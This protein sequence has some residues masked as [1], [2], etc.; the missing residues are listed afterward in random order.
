[1]GLGA[2]EGNASFVEGCSFNDGYNGGIGVFGT[3]NLTLKNNV[4]YRAVG[5]AIDLEGKDH[6]VIGNLLT[7]SLSILTFRVGKIYASADLNW[8]G[9]LNLEKAKDFTVTGN[10]IAGAEK[11]G[12]RFPGV[13]CDDNTKRVYGNEVCNYFV[14]VSRDLLKK[15]DIFQLIISF[16]R[17]FPNKDRK[18]LKRKRFLI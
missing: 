9:A 13:P 8:D 6:K 15:L 4:I 1:M 7:T 10:S 5:P 16:S 3:N 12:I 17:Y 14:F 2:I 11:V 18:E